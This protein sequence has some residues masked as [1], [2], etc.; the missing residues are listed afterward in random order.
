MRAQ[1]SADP[2]RVHVEHLRDEQ[3][4]SDDILKVRRAYME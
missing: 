3:Y 1:L 2:L 4:N